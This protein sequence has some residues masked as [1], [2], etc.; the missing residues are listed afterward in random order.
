MKDK[1]EKFISEHR[2][3][4]DDQ[5]PSLKLWDN[6]QKRVAK[7]ERNFGWVWKVAAVLLLGLSLTLLFERENREELLVHEDEDVSSE[8]LEVEQHYS[9]IILAKRTEIAHLIEEKKFEDVEVLKDLD[10]LDL[11]YDQ[12]KEDLKKNQNDDRVVN[13]MIRN[14]QLRVEILSKQLEILKKLKR[15]EDYEIVS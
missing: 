12:L 14:L 1:L 4:F 6:I 13:A 11:M 9:S 7:P 3:D 10:A 15:N 2:Q 5:E 8:I